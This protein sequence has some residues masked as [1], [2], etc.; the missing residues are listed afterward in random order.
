MFARPWVVGRTLQSE[1]QRHFHAVVT[2]CGDE[3]V[4]ILDGA[5]LRVYRVVSTL[6]AANRPGRA[7]IL[8]CGGHAVVAALA[9]HL[10]DR[11]DGRKVDHVEAH[12]GDARQRLGGRRKGAVHGVA[13]GVPATGGPGKDLVPRAEPSQRPV[14]PDPVLLAAGDQFAQRIGL[15][16]LG[17]LRRQRGAGA[18]ERVT[19]LAQPA[20][21]LDQ[22]IA[23]LPGHARRGAL[24]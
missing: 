5:Q 13:R 15:Q 7:D 21:R 10:A 3:I 4:E 23:V 6:V 2:G 19:G 12:F 14:H 11:M 18:G 24:Q 17:H 9:V 1:V 22:G 8:G 16:E 20:R